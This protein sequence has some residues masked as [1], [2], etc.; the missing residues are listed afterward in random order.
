M[1]LGP[2]EL[3]VIG[4]ENGQFNGEIIP[5]LERLVSAGVISI[6]DGIFVQKTA[7]D[8]VVIVEF[9]DVDGDP[10]IDALGALL[11]EVQGLISDEDVDTLIDTLPVGAAAAVLCF[12]HTWVVPLR[13][14]IVN[15]GGE[16]LESVRVPGAVVQEVLDAVAALD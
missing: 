6:V 5:E 3:V 15:A 11:A 9:D 13:D 4:F 16:L 10:A 1:T 8:E 14:A 7:D 2:I 12:E